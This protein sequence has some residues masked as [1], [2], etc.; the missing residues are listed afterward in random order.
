MAAATLK[1]GCRRLTS[2][3]MVI[4]RASRHIPTTQDAEKIRQYDKLSHDTDAPNSHDVRR[5]KSALDVRR[6]EK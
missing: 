2:R 5:K 6:D 3:K 4:R 1:N